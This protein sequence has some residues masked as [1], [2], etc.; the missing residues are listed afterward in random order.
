M[1]RRISLAIAMALATILPATK[2]RGQAAAEYGILSSKSATA[3][4]KASTVM[5]PRLKP[6]G[7][8]LERP[9][10]KSPLSQ[11][12]QNR[13]SL[14]AKAAQ[15]GATLRVDS[16]PAKARVSVDGV[17]VAFTPADL[18]LPEGGHSVEVIQPGYL[19]WKQQVSLAP[20]ETQSLKAELENKYKSAVTLAPPK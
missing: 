5:G 1:R 19:P 15:G 7:E 16:T 10:S 20:G 17:V 11:M 4:T 13:R 8:R 12:Q 6:L 9:E 3:A 2:A 14:E 18:K